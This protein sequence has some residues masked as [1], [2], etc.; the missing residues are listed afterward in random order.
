MTVKLLFLA[1]LCV[2]SLLGSGCTV[3]RSSSSDGTGSFFATTANYGMQ[4]AE[5]V[6]GSG[7]I[8]GALSSD[9][10]ASRTITPIQAPEPTVIT[11]PDGFTIT[12]PSIDHGTPVREVFNGWRNL[13]MIKGLRDVWTALIGETGDVITTE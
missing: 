11:M 8:A 10:G 6:K 3:Y 2:L 13:A 4:Q 12:T 7:G 5:E 1:G 9:A